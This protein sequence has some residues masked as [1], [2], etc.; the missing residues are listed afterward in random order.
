L[1]ESKKRLRRRAGN[2][3]TPTSIEECE[4]KNLFFR[5][6]DARQPRPARG[7]NYKEPFMKTTRISALLLGSALFFAGGIL[8]G[9][10]SNKKPLHIAESVV[11]EGKTLAPGDYK[12]EWTEPG[13][14]VQ[15]TIL[16][17]K[18]AVVTVPAHLVSLSA[19]NVQ[20]SY[21]TSTGQDGSKTLTQVAFGGTKYQLEL[22]PA[23]AAAVGAQTSDSGRPN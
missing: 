21:S 8:A 9:P 12:I 14:N 15:V 20:T 17:G 10:A 19:S 6:R 1:L 4:T 11:V 22:A 5:Q 13:P 3:F 7:E 23:S 16:Q 2:R 18:S